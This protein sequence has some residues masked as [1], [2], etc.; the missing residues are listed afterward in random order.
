MITG[1]G[2]EPPCRFC[3]Q[4]AAE[5]EIDAC[6]AVIGPDGIGAAILTQMEAAGLPEAH[7]LVAWPIPDRSR[8][9]TL[10]LWE[11]ARSSVR[12]NTFG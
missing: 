7:T 10:G 9:D 4:G 5:A 11:A 6:R 12:N 3:F 2:A 8:L 1:N